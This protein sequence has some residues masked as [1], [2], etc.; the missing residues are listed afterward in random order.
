MKLNDYLTNLT[1]RGF[2]LENGDLNEKYISVVLACYLAAGNGE[3]NAIIFDKL[4]AAIIKRLKDQEVTLE[5][6][7][8]C[9]R[10]WWG[11]L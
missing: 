5:E 1:K 8:H 7:D 6:T 10:I 2:D 11:V 9:V 4:P 3:D